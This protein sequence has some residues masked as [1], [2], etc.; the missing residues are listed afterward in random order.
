[1]R[2]CVPFAFFLVASVAPAQW[3]NHR[4]RATPRNADGKANLT[5]PAPRARDGHPDLSGVWHVEPTPAAELTKMFG[6][7]TA[8]SVPGDD[9]YSLNKYT[10]SVF[11]DFKP[12]TE[13]IRPEFAGRRASPADNPTSRCLPAGIPFGQMLPAPFKI[14]QTPDLLLILRN[15]IDGTIRQVYT[16]GR[17]VP[18][19]AEPLWLGYSVGHWQG[20]TMVIDTTGFNDKSWLDGFGHPHSDALHITER[21]HRRDFGHMD[22]AVTI[23]DPKIYTKPVTFQVTDLLFPDTDVMEAYCTEDE[24]DISHLTNSR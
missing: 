9:F 20:D 10:L 21:Y 4:D 15:E 22:V 8:L 3:L 13:P 18:A 16:D 11:A 24:K 1:M 17:T 19:G 23:D 7:Q 5:A 2:G 14:V 12:G 6:D